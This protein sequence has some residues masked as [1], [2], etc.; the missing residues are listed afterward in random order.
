MRILMLGA[1]GR[2]GRLALDRLAGAGHEVVTY[3]RRPGGGARALTGALDDVAALRGALDGAEAVVACLASTNAEPTCSTATR[4]LIEA[5]EGRALR[6]VLVSGAGVDA[7]GDAKGLSDKAIG[8]LMRAV[9][10]RML[11]DRQAE[12]DLLR[13]SDLLWTALRPPRLV[14]GDGRGTWRFTFDRPAATKIARADLAGAL[15]EAL[16]RDDL[17][18]RAPFVSER[19]G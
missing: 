15:V 13:A 4:A 2:T 3:G 9:V 1:T 10:G 17:V 14:D 6:Y 8:L 5:A 12:L 7:P 16:G 18:G 19:R 11:A